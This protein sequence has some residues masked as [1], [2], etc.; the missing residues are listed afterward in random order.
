MISATPSHSENTALEESG[1]HATPVQRRKYVKRYCWIIMSPVINSFGANIS[2]NRF[3]SLITY[4]L[5][6]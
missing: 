3:V 6:R 1:D 2:L 4:N 5:L